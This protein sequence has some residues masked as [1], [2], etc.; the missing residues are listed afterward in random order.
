MDINK[1]IGETPEALRREETIRAAADKFPND[2]KNDPHSAIATAASAIIRRGLPLGRQ[3]ILNMNEALG[4]NFPAGDTVLLGALI[5]ASQVLT[6]LLLERNPLLILQLAE[7]AAIAEQVAP[8]V[9]RATQAFL[10]GKGISGT[11][12]VYDSDDGIVLSMRP[13]AEKPDDKR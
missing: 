2:P 7:A 9:R 13:D 1:I 10:D 8:M 5:C 6:D 11:G 4:G 12:V 3:E